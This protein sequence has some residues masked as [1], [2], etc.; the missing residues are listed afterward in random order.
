MYARLEFIEM[1]KLVLQKRYQD[2][3]EKQH[4]GYSLCVK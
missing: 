1:K 4:M 2:P 3:M